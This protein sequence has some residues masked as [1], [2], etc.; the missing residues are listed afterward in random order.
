MYCKHCGAQIDDD[1]KV[2]SVCGKQVARVQGQ[3]PAQAPVQQEPVQ[4]A[5]VQQEPAPQPVVAEKPTGLKKIFLI[6]GSVA[7]FLA[8]LL[9]FGLLFAGGVQVNS[10]FGSITGVGF[11]TVADYFDFSETGII[12]VMES[13]ADGGK[14]MMGNLISMIFSFILI[15]VLIIVMFVFFI[16]GIVAFVKAMKGQDYEK[17]GKV[18]SRAFET[19]TVG[20]LIFLILHVTSAEGFTVGLNSAAIAGIVLTAL[21]VGVNFVMHLLT[22]GFG[23][24]NLK[25]IL[26]IVFTALILC[27]GAI[28]AGLASGATY[29]TEASSSGMF[30][31]FTQSITALAMTAGMDIVT[32]AYAEMLTYSLFGFLSAVLV[33][34]FGVELIRIAMNNVQAIGDNK[35]GKMAGLGMSITAL[36]FSI[37]SVVMHFLFAGAAEQSDALNPAIPIVIAVFAILSIVASV[38]TK[39]F[40][41]DAAKK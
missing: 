4:Q 11:Y 3:Q 7:A 41:Q 40:A 33:V 26:S 25:R 20:M 34:T 2:C 9:A 19:F 29:V 23:L 18:A 35:P 14:S 16:M 30:V 31:L 22:R 13:L 27:S 1:S 21:L 37:I 24:F 12:K 36:V 5:P 38:L 39:K 17:I 15:Y 6:I 32:G 8:V 10:E 28:V